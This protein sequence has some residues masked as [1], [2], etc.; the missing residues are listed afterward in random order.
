MELIALLFVASIIIGVVS[1]GPQI[2]TLAH[3]ETTAQSLS[4]SAFG[5]WFMLSLVD[6]AYVLIQTD[7]S[8][9]ITANAAESICLAVITGLAIYKRHFSAAAKEAGTTKPT[10]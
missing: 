5:I 3:V 2:K 1:Y 4:I 10:P 7:D 9:I 8:L 6:L